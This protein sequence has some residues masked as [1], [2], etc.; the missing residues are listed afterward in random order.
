MGQ[1]ID[2]LRE[3]CIVPNSEFSTKQQALKAIAKAAKK[4]SILN[5]ISEDEIYN[6]LEEREAIGSTGFESGIAI[7]HCR[8]EKV[9]EF[10]VGVISVPKGVDFESID[11]EDT[12]LIFYIIGPATETNE[13]IRILS[14]ISRVCRISKAINE[15]VSS[16]TPEAIKECFSRYLIDKIEE[17]KNAPKCQFH[18]C[19]ADRDVFLQ[20]LQVFTAIDN[21]SV[22]V[23]EARHHSEYLA[24]IP[25][26]M[27]F[28]NDTSE[29]PLQL[30]TAIVEKSLTNETIR[31]IEGIIDRSDASDSVQMNIHELLYSSGIIKA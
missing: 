9:T 15:M 31:K 5:N 21:S 28:W 13:H 25:L 1:L 24:E 18:V 23:L 20:I 8:L 14:T 12:K 30:I 29:N 27:G 3:E 4:S 7:P 10:V 19:V 22:T 2:S 16:K 26:F 6:A 11:G 17:K